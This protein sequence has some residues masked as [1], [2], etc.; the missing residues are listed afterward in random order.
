MVSS[1]IDHPRFDEWFTAASAL[2]AASHD[3]WD[4]M[5]DLEGSLADLVATCWPTPAET[6]AKKDEVRRVA[7][8]DLS[9]LILPTP[10][11]LFEAERADLRDVTRYGD[12][13]DMLSSSAVRQLLGRAEALK[14]TAHDLARQQSRVQR[15]EAELARGRTDL[16]A[17]ELNLVRRVITAVDHIVL[18]KRCR[19]IEKESAALSEKLSQVRR[20][21]DCFTIGFER[22]M[23]SF[24]IAHREVA[25]W[26]Q[27]MGYLTQSPGMPTAYDTIYDDERST[28]ERL[29]NLAKHGRDMS[30]A[31][32]LF[33]VCSA[34]HF[35]ARGLDR[36][37]VALR[38]LK[39]R[40]DELWREGTGS[41]GLYTLV[42]TRTAAWSAG[43][44]Q[45][46]FRD[47]ARWVDRGGRHGDEFSSA[48]L[49]DRA[50][51]DSFRLYPR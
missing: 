47:W 30:A 36:Y 41:R 6:A 45:I 25:F 51:T 10:P 18:E 34:W 42:G 49:L 39:T 29:A 50:I 17:R 32:L 24:Q 12:Q 20:T 19:A 22:T 23:E 38:S 11:A 31:Q 2:E 13:P 1:V 43:H 4:A 37:E 28:E 15:E 21:F 9:A 16:A 40:V 46:S 33:E 8:T 5:G 14:R 35:A 26:Q 44:R 27:L 7:L 48:A 3:A